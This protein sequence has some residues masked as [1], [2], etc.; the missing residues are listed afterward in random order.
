MRVTVE[1]PDK[2]S[3]GIGSDVEQVMMG[4]MRAW[5]TLPIDA[6]KTVRELII[7]YH[8]STTLPLPSDVFDIEVKMLL[9]TNGVSEEHEASLRINDFRK[10]LSTRVS[11]A[12]S[13]AVKMKIEELGHQYAE[14]ARLL[15]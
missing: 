5:M 1:L 7:S 12:V 3:I 6:Q 11:N 15:L 8:G 14:V 4:A 10:D 9:E 13:A 2:M